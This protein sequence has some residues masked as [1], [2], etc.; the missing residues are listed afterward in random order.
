MRAGPATLEA[1]QDPARRD[2]EFVE[3]KGLGH[4]DTLC[5]A[6]AEEVS[7]ALGAAYLARF[8]RILHH[9]VDK[10]LLVA[11]SSAP[12]FGGGRILEPARVVIA[13]RA[14]TRAGGE[15][16]DAAGIALE[17]ARACIRAR[18]R[19]L[20]PLRDMAFECRIREGS[21]DLRALFARGGRVPLANDSS[22]GAGFAPFSPLE[23][24]VAG[25]ERALNAP[26]TRPHPGCGEDV[27]VCATRVGDAARLAI[28]CAGVAPLLA[29][30]AAY[31]EAMDGA[32]G[33]ARGLAAGEAA[34]GLEAL[35]VNAAD[36]PGGGSWYLTVSGTSAEA[37]DDGATGRGN[38][39]SGLV[40]P[41]RP[42]CM[43]AAAG[44]N[45][46]SHPGKL[47]ALAAQDLAEEIAAAVE[48]VAAVECLMASRIGAPMDEPALF[49]LRVATRPGVALGDVAP[50]LG[51]RA[52]AARARIP[53][54]WRRIVAGEARLF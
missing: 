36:D 18:L 12:R 40:A 34:I 10:V 43:E 6:I 50:A 53:G 28:A 23:R 3:R 13:G 49:H 42:A 26:G 14:T 33:V 20:D 54:L 4:P 46:A 1:M 32:A 37:G 5:D 30:P 35:A 29:G 11:G 7:R 38:R 15:E 16:I 8:G 52:E 39:A 27:K 17:A 51:A 45:P 21:A 22:A 48:G 9:N 24:L 31:R 19:F 2:A 44:K 47:Y 25:C 41:G